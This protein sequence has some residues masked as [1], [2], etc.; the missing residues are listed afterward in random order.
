M[1]EKIPIGCKGLIVI[2]LDVVTVAVL[3]FEGILNFECAFAICCFDKSNQV[4]KIVL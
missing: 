2:K 4:G 1:D 3:H